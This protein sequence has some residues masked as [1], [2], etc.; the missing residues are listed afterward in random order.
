MQKRICKYSK[1]AF[2]GLRATF[3]I[4][5]SLANIVLKHLLACFVVT[6]WFLQ[7]ASQRVQWLW[8]FSHAIDFSL[9]NNLTN[10][11]FC[12]KKLF[13]IVKYSTQIF[14]YKELCLGYMQSASGDCT[15]AKKKTCRDISLCNHSQFQ[16]TQLFASIRIH[17]QKMIPLLGCT[18]VST[19]VNAAHRLVDSRLQIYNSI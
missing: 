2:V 14:F 10:T 8:I 18:K 13:L 5:K 15:L 16:V 4:N 17:F 3:G 19:V 1:T 7:R 6:V 9:T 11:A 12:I